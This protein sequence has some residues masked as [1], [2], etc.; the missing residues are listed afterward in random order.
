MT[1]MRL[2]Y[3]PNFDFL[4]STP[5]MY[6]ES[7]LTGTLIPSCVFPLATHVADFS[8]PFIAMAGFLS[9][10]TGLVFFSNHLTAAICPKADTETRKIANT[11]YTLFIALASSTITNAA[12]YCLIDKLDK[13]PAIGVASVSSLVLIGSCFKM[14]MNYEREQQY[15][16]LA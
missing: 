2:N 11:W 14:K 4:T 9:L 5:A 7:I 12:V 10:L 8:S 6:V 15:Q 13:E 3:P 1:R 16:Q